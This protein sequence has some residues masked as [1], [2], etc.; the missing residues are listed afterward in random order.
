M[1][2]GRPS[3]YDPEIAADICLRL[4]ICTKSLVSIL[5]ERDEFPEH[6]TFYRWMLNHEELRTLYA[7]ARDA[8]LQILADEI[9]EIADEPQ[10]GE[11]VTIKGDEREVKISDMLEHRKLRIDA[12]KW[13]LSKLAPKKYGD[14][15]AITGDGGGPLQ[16]ITSIPRPP[17]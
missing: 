7:H 17:Q 3:D 10:S 11:V 14:K 4:S 9:Q 8:Q 12:R 2:A 5:S 6:S 15:T 1:P 13:L 16:I